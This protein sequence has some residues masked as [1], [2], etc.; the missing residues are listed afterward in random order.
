MTAWPYGDFYPTKGYALHTSLVV[1]TDTLEPLLPPGP[2]VLGFSG[3]DVLMTVAGEWDPP[4]T[5]DTLLHPPEKP[6]DPN[7]PITRGVYTRWEA[8]LRFEPSG[9]VLVG[10]PIG[11]FHINGE[12][13]EHGPPGVPT[14]FGSCGP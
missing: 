7:Q 9:P 3:E 10:S 2:L 13:G 5:A 11:P 4:Q 12:C 1:D 8:R 14:R 6:F